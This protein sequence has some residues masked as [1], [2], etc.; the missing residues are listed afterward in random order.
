ML[1][2][3]EYE[4][5]IKHPHNKQKYKDVGENKKLSFPHRILEMTLYFPMKNDYRLQ[6]IWKIFALHF[7]CNQPLSMLQLT[8]FLRVQILSNIAN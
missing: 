2:S 4:V 1:S 3:Q 8:S 6:N 7:F 5:E